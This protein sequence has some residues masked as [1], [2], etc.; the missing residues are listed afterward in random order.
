[1][2]TPFKDKIAPDQDVKGDWGGSTNGVDIPGGQKGTAG[3]MPEV[4]FVDA[5]GGA[6]VGESSNLGGLG[7]GKD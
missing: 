4:T 3:I 2:N 7:G 5:P 6:N 1:M